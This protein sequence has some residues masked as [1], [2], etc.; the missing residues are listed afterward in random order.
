MWFWCYIWMWFTQIISSFLSIFQKFFR[1]QFTKSV[2]KPSTEAWSKFSSVVF[3]RPH[4]SKEEEGSRFEL[5]QNSALWRRLACATVNFSLQ[6]LVTA[7]VPLRDGLLGVFFAISSGTTSIVRMT[8][9]IT[10]MFVGIFLSVQMV[11]SN[12]SMVLSMID[13]LVRSLAGI[14]YCASTFIN[15]LLSVS[16]SLARIKQPQN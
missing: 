16:A 8:K 12:V 13:Y 15:T 1:W 5:N 11:M 3:I 6:P 10:D 2:L 14:Q 7:C 9:T 4:I